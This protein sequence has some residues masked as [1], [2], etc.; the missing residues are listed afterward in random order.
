MDARELQSMG[1][2]A[3]SKSLSP[4]RRKEI[5]RLAASKRWAGMSP[6]AIRRKTRNA[7][8]AMTEARIR[9][10]QERKRNGH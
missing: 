10:A 1:G 6:D 8:K 3:R 4:A 7:I 5:A 9:L 2:L